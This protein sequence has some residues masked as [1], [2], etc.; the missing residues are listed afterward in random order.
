MMEFAMHGR[1]TNG[2]GDRF[3][4]FNLARVPAAEPETVAFTAHF[5]SDFP[6]ADSSSPESDLESILR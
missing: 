3:L 4:L 1:A 6:D 5:P 2:L